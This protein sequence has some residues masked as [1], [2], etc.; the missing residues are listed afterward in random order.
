MS[1]AETFRVSADAYDRLVGRYSEQLASALIGFA[2]VQPGTCAVDVG[3]GPGAL[4]AALVRLLGKAC[5]RAVDPSA[6][7]VR[8]CRARLP[9]VDVATAAAEH[10][11]FADGTFDVALSQLVVNFMAD[12][13]AGVREMARVTRPGGIVASCVWD[14]A[15]EMTLL[16]AFW[17]A[18]G[19]VDPQRAAGAD[20]GVVMSYCADGD[21]ARLW[22]DAGLSD[23]RRGELV[24]SATYT[25]F[26]DLWA[27]LPTGVGPSGAFCASLPEDRRAALHD[28]FL[29]RLA[30]GAGPFELTARAW[31]VSGIVGH[32]DSQGD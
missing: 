12:A 25:D 15:G 2:G 24:V 9:G 3:C 22:R 18:A 11:P 5:V 26:E 28:A 6:Q 10:L 7:F 21:L 8:A 19:E 27:P 16:R 20:E 30:V 29:R 4:T 14:Y 23:V 31:A 32:H 1:G 17:D 13:E